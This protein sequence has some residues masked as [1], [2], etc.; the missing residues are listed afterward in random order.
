MEK[1]YIEKDKL[2]KI[3]LTKSVRVSMLDLEE[4]ANRG[5][6]VADALRVGLDT[7]LGRVQGVTAPVVAPVVQKGSGWD[8]DETW[9]LHV[10]YLKTSQNVEELYRN[11][12][13]Y[14]G[15]MFELGKKVPDEAKDFCD[16]LEAALSA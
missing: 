12:D 3:K 11:W 10:D 14:R 9:L 15:E 16:E 8:S 2:S 6:S 5:I 1:I 4:L 7:V 13:D